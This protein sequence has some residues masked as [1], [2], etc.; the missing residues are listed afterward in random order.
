MRVVSLVN[1]SL[2]SEVASFYAISYAKSIESPLTFLFVDNGLES[3]EQFQSSIASLEEIAEANQ[4]NFETVILKGDVI[5][6]IKHFAQLY[7]I[8][9]VFCATRKQSKAASFS[10]KIIASG[11]ET[12]IA[13]VKVKNVSQVHSFRRV[14]LVAGETINPHCYLLWIGLISANQALGKLYLQNNRRVKKASSKSGFKY[15]ASPFVQLAAMLKQQI[16]VVQVLQPI[17]PALMNNYLVENDLDLAIYDARAFPKKI[18]NQMTDQ[19]GINSILF[20]PWQV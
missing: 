4:V 6:Q 15:L 19:S 20:Y 3:I 9:T 1:G 18:L 5:S 8:N 11:L 17:N 14:L 13:V 2:L 12:A 16:E 7:S 10:D